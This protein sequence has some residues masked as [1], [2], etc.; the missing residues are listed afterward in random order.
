MA[1]ERSFA[2][3]LLA[4]GANLAIAIAKLAAGLVAGS[5][6]ML[7]EAAHSL[8][9][10]ANQVLLVTALRRSR[11]PADD[12]HPFGYGMER[13]FWSLLASI[14]VLVVGAGI[15]IWLGVRAW[16]D[17]E[18]LL[19]LG[20]AAVVLAVAFCFEGAS[21]VRG[22]WQ[23]R[24]DAAD[25]QTSPWQWLRRA[26]EPTA[27]AVVLEDSA[28]VLGIAIAALGLWLGR[29]TSDSRYDAAA[30]IAIGLLL[31]AV[32]L[33]LARRNQR[34]L[35]GRSVEP[36]KLAEIR[37]AIAGIEGIRRV[38]S[39]RTM[40]LGPD[41]VLVAAKVSV[42]GRLTG[43]ELEV[44]ADRV[45]ERIRARDARVRHVFVDPTPCRERDVG[46]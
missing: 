25:H 6:G 19:D 28:A 32:A 46:I 23:I 33:S 9:D 31:A 30:S 35:I 39:L 42:D 45:E 4:G 16:L 8:G 40:Q 38:I 22:W 34:M 5:A 7:A 3:V 26:S 36:E 37:G 18:P 43:A 2:T 27:R 10:T 12:E 1:Q 41:E 24:R 15:S 14:S 13:Y 29:T 11:I 17:P 21:L 20:A 44:V